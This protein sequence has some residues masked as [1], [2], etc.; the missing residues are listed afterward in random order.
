MKNLNGLMLG[1]STSLLQA[2][3]SQQTEK[4]QVLRQSLQDAKMGAV[5]GEKR[6]GARQEEM[7]SGLQRSIAHRRT[8]KQESE[9]NVV[10][11][12]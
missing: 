4:L 10:Y 6:E 7:C 5:R 12:I 8:D 9:D 3:E 2:G 11:P 1:E